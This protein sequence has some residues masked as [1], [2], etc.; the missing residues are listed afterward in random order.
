[1]ELLW[2]KK[3]LRPIYIPIMERILF[4]RMQ[5]KYPLMIMSSIQ[6]IRYIKKHNC[7]I[8]RYGDG[9][10]HTMFN[11]IDLG[12]QA[13]SASLAERL[14]RVIAESDERL[15]VCYPRCIVSTKG[16]KPFG[17]RYWTTWCLGKDMRVKIFEF[18][19]MCGMHTKFFGDAFLTRPYIDW[20]SR[21]RAGRIF[22]E[23]KSIWQGRDLLI[24][25]GDQTRLGIGNDL[26]DNAKSIKRILAP[27]VNA[28]DSYE[29]IKETVIQTYCGELV[30]I[31]LGPTATVL[32]ADLSKENIQALDIGH[33]DIEY[34]WFLRNVQEKEAVPG[35]YTNEVWAGHEFS[36]CNDPSY[37]SQIVKRIET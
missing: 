13:Y 20:K 18:T 19:R 36:E 10:F 14:K 31:A 28:Y 9:E 3:I 16:M 24:V 32:A 33:I 2:A 11:S 21:K 35:K 4:M 1:M 37:Q 25:E 5:R 7:S 22:A 29:K 17:A 34:E 6:T 23:L 15:L 26:F 12:F 27:A 8:S 30:L